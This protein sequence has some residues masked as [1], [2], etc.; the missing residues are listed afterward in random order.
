MMGELGRSLAGALHLAFL[1]KTAAARFPAD[2]AGAL[3]SFW[4]MLILLPGLVALDTVDRWMG[5]PLVLVG[6]GPAT[7][8]VVPLAQ[9]IPSLLLA[10]TIGTLAYFLMV[11]RI[12]H[13]QGN[14]ALFPRLVAGF[15]WSGVVALI[16]VL[17]LA[18]LAHTGWLSTPMAL[19]IVWV[20]YFWNLFY[21]AYVAR[22]ILGT[23]WITATGFVFLDV[24]TTE[25]AST[26]VR[27]PLMAAVG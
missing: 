13:L 14:G 26:L 21:E 1:D 8:P 12:L 27:G 5:H 18:A 15:N 20:S 22:A 17:P 9:A 24:V 23:G 19:S 25:L 6:E 16:V 3:R 2:R 7:A 10:Y 11:E 4:V